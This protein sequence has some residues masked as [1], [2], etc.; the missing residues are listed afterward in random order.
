MKKFKQY[1]GLNFSSQKKNINL[2]KYSKSTQYK[3]GELIIH[4]YK[5]CHAIK[6]IRKWLHM[7]L[8]FA[9]NMTKYSNIKPI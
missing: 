2:A 5:N 8:I 9:I 4:G 6:W 7:L 3:Q 1:I